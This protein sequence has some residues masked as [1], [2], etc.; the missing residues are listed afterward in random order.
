P[1]LARATRYGD[2]RGTDTGA[3]RAV[4]ERV[5]ARICAGLPPAAHGIDDDEAARLSALVDGVHAVTGL[6]G[7]EATERWLSALARRAE[8]PARPPLRAGRLA[9]LLAATDRMA[10]GEGERRRAR[11][12]TP[13]TPAAHAGAYVEG[14]F[15]GGALLLVHDERL[16]RIVDRW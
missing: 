3:L 9:R 13:G 16:L 14:F 4:A 5:L 10:P 2:V 7:E 12:L 8:R 15:A 11:A 6:L 1:A